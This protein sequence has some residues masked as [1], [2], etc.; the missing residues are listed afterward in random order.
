MRGGKS[1]RE[2]VPSSS[3]ARDEIRAREG[4][5]IE[6]FASVHGSVNVPRIRRRAD[7][8]LSEGEIFLDLALRSR[9]GNTANQQGDQ[10]PFL[11]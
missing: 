3:P 10:N 4:R 6:S 7:D 8:V 9:D 5:Q 11:T 1:A 2:E